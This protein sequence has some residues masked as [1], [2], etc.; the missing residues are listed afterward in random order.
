MRNP[1][2]R[3]L[4]NILGKILIKPFEAGSEALGPSL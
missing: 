3:Y 4:P 2:V 1:T